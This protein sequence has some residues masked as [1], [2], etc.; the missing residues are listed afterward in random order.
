M[1]KK[2]I[3]LSITLIA[4][5]II[6]TSFANAVVVNGTVTILAPNVTVTP[7]PQI[8]SGGGSSGVMGVTTD[9]PYGN[10]AFLE[11]IEKHWYYN[12]SVLYSFKY[13][14]YEV[15]VLPLQS[16]GAVILKLEILKAKSNKTLLP[17]DS[18]YGYFNL[19]SGSKRFKDGI[20]RFRTNIDWDVDVVTLMKWTGTEWKPL[21]TVEI[22]SDITYKYYEAYTD[23][24]SNF[25][26]VGTPKTV[27][28]ITTP[29]PTHY[30]T[31]IIN[32]T[33]EIPEEKGIITNYIIFSFVIIGIIIIA[34]GY[35]IYINIDKEI[36]NKKKK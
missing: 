10:I 3:I 14:I 16:E 31:T 13:D 32:E 24:F 19:Y 20:I 21:T 9:E 33:V 7:T 27:E 11:R 15:V 18:V 5:F 6:L 22:G 28:V 4:L 8:G 30:S 34:I 12:K 2:I 23:T 25:V 17:I 36:N 29:Q 26:I 35:I 1:N